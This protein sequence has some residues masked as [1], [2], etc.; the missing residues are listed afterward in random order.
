MAAPE[1]DEVWKPYDLFVDLTPH[2][3]IRLSCLKALVHDPADK[4]HRLVRYGLSLTFDRLYT[5]EPQVSLM[6]IINIRDRFFGLLPDCTSKLLAW[7][8]ILRFAVTSCAF[9]MILVATVLLATEIIRSN[10]H[11]TDAIV[12]FTLI[13]LTVVLEFLPIIT[14]FGTSTEKN[15]TN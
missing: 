14:H 2:H 1:D 9:L 10:D 5:K 13:L 6:N 11:Y 3:L 8:R 4:A 15:R 12:T 7:I